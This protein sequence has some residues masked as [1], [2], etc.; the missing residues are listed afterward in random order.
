MSSPRTRPDLR[1]PRSQDGARL[2]EIAA[3]SRVLDVNSS[4]AYLLWCRDFAT[5][6]I[7]AEIAGRVVGFV[8][9]YRRPPAPNTLFV[10]QVAVEEAYRGRG[11]AAAMLDHLVD[12]I[13][14]DTVE[15]TI[16]PDNAGSI[17]LF[18][19]LARTRA[20]DLRVRPLFT[21]AEFPDAHDAEDLYHITPIARKTSAQPR[22]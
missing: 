18:T 3:A 20:A 16:T 8:T 22:A 21:V 15:T 1:H 9:G 10:W 2:W 12:C 7:V 5:S 11:I 17:A 19:A 6:S 4:Y 14:V 13:E